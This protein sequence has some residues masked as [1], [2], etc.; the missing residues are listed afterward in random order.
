M[1]DEYFTPPSITVTSVLVGAAPR[2]VDLSDSLVSMLIDQDAPSTSIP[3]A[4]EQ[5]H[6]LKISQDTPMVEKSKVDGDL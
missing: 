3:S 1:F 6:S 5:D 2:A 4:Q